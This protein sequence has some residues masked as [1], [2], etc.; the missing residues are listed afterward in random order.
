[1][2]TSHQGGMDGTDKVR[3]DDLLLH[4]VHGRHIPCAEVVVAHLP[5]EIAQLL[6]SDLVALLLLPLPYPS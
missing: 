4:I 5:V 6:H 2:I 1:M 3:S